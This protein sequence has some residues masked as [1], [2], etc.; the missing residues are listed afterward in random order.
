MVAWCAV[1]SM[2]ELKCIKSYRVDAADP[3]VPTACL[4]LA[5]GLCASASDASPVVKVWDPNLPQAAPVVSFEAAAPVHA[6]ASDHSTGG[7]RHLYT[8]GR[9]HERRHEAL[10]QW[11]LEAA[12]EVQSLVDPLNAGDHYPLP[13]SALAYSKGMLAATQG[14]DVALYD[15]RV[16]LAPV[17]RCWYEPAWLLGRP[18][19]QFFCTRH[20]PPPLP[21]PPLHPVCLQ[22]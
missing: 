12:Q 5:G 14:G 19:V 3:V 2:D 9:G 16:P 20:A 21:S 4:M 7:H 13:I 11:D 15:L 6:L 8:G 22:S 10:Q 1:W 18:P 17:L